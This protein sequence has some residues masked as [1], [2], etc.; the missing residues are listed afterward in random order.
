MELEKILAEAV[1]LKASDIHL[2][3]GQKV[4]IRTAGELVQFG[5]ILTAKDFE[6]ILAELVPPR[7][8]EDLNKN[9][10]VDFSYKKFSRRFRINVYF[11]SLPLQFD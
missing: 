10:S 1:N 9:L 6:N 5:E 8:R 4:F 3:A 7:L 2:T 11:H